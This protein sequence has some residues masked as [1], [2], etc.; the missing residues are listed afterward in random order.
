[1]D[2]SKVFYLSKVELLSQL[3]IDELTELANDFQ[4]EQHYSGSI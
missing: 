4:W 1:M 2:R 3:T